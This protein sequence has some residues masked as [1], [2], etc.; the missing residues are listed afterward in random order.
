[1]SNVS[2]EMRVLCVRLEYIH[3]NQ[4]FAPMWDLKKIGNVGKYPF[5]GYLTNF[6]YS[7]FYAI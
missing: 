1:M 6:D 4:F 5:M 3:F 7:V 2:F